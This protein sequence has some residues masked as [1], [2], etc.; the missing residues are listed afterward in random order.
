[1]VFIILYR[2]LLILNFIKKQS[3][4]TKN[5][6]YCRWLI[7]IIC[8]PCVIGSVTTIKWIVNPWF[9]LWRWCSKKS[10]L[11]SILIHRCITPC[12][13]LH[14]SMFKN[15][16]KC[17]VYSVLKNILGPCS[18]IL[19]RKCHIVGHSVVMR[20]EGCSERIKLEDWAQCTTG[21]IIRKYHRSGF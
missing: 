3:Q 11:F 5:E 13:P 19:I 6:N 18:Q 10:I 17:I 7:Q 1:M 12:H 21:K 8:A 16:L 9:W 15:R 20:F 4:N 14:S 2:N